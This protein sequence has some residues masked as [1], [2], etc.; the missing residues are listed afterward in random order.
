M[1]TDIIPVIYSLRS[2][3]NGSCSHSEQVDA[4]A[5]ALQKLERIYAD[6][7]N[8]EI[9]RTM[10]QMLADQLLHDSIDVNI[11]NHLQMRGFEPI[12][13]AV[14]SSQIPASTDDVN[15][16][17]YQYAPSSNKKQKSGGYSMSF[18]FDDFP[19]FETVD[20]MLAGLRNDRTDRE[21]LNKILALDL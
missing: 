8:L 4:I 13:R 10:K 9:V 19:M 18:N 15:L 14:I 20:S 21:S 6:Y 12:R 5:D 3:L 7:D 2:K 11:R 1:S 17:G 16:L